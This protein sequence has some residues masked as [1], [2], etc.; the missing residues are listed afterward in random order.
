[1]SLH[2]DLACYLAQ[3]RARGFKLKTSEYLLRQF[4]YWLEGH[5]STETF[6]IADAVRWACDR[7][8]SAPV[9][10]SQRLTAVRPFAAW[11]NARDGVV[12]RIPRGLL[13]AAT[14]RRDP[15][16][17]SQAE[18]NRLLVA[19]PLF[20]ANVRVAA[21]MSTIIGLLAATGL[22]IGEAVALRIAD[23]D[24]TGNLLTVPGRKTPLDRLIPLDPSTTSALVD[25]INLPERPRTNPS[26]VGPIFVN[27]RGRGITVDAID[28]YFQ[29]LV[30]ALEMAPP[31]R[32]RPTLH[33]L[34]H[35]FATRHMVAAYTRED[36]DPARTLTLLSTWLGHTAPEHTYWYLT[37]VPELLAAAAGRLEPTA[38]EGGSR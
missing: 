12:P 18:V 21:T 31:G 7:P 11:L 19:C 34:R 38:D 20:F 24:V 17:Y 35:T 29:V 26:P 14:T 1:M 30:D 4:C 8:G 28:H 3:R 32:R 2:D 36:G 10:C 5:G 37:A 22:R 13:P 15:F 23:L 16:I 6:T 25:Y 9:W 33:C 27:Y